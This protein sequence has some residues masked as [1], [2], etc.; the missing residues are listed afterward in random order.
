MCTEGGGGG[1]GSFGR[2]QIYPHG[3]IGGY[4]HKT[5]LETNLTERG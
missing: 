5:P 3:A 4:C 2:I 1:G